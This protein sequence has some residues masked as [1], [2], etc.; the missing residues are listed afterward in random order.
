MGYMELEWQLAGRIKSVLIVVLCALL[1]LYYAY[2]AGDKLSEDNFGY[3]FKE[4]AE[5]NIETGVQVFVT[6]GQALSYDNPIDAF[7]L[8]EEEIPESMRKR[9]LILYLDAW[10]AELAH[11]YELIE[12]E[13]PESFFRENGYGQRALQAFNSFSEA[14]GYLEDYYV[15]DVFSSGGQENSLT[16]LGVRLELIRIQTLRLY[17]EIGERGIVELRLS[18]DG[19]LEKRKLEAS[20]LYLFSEREAMQMLDA[21]YK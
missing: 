18:E 12:G 9:W 21:A 3:N 20:D 17:E 13:L 7:F 11:A 10:E 14:Q 19:Q 6:D 8:G 16:M 4:N 5:S 1:V 15:N 2:T